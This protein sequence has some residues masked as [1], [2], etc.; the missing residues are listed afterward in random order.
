[1]TNEKVEVMTSS[2][3]VQ[4]VT[5][6]HHSLFLAERVIAC[7]KAARQSDE[8]RLGEHHL[9]D[10]KYPET[11]WKQVSSA[12]LCTLESLDMPLAVKS[13][14]K[15][16]WK[17][18]ADNLYGDD[19]PNA[20][21][22]NQILCKLLSITGGISEGSNRTETM[23]YCAD[24]LGFESPQDVKYQIWSEKFGFVPSQH[25][26]GIVYGQGKE[27]KLD[28]LW[29]K[30]KE[31]NC[32]EALMGALDKANY[33]SECKALAALAALCHL[34]PPNPRTLVPSNWWMAEK[35]L[36]NAEKRA[37]NPEYFGGDLLQRQLLWKY[38]DKA[39]FQSQMEQW[40]RKKA[41]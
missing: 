26:V 20:G 24:L 36:D 25:R 19:D 39:R 31:A 41:I 28:K 23:N 13:Y 1:M 7:V 35:V 37:S 32:L 18:I 22:H 40:L 4:K 14:P 33:E 6:G 30:K 11:G 34:A 17:D 16:L 9:L 21:S 38:L 12:H 8:L 5:P 2:Q 27:F 29:G 15:D 10:A 3:L